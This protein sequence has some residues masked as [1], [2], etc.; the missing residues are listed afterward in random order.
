[1]KN[2]RQFYNCSIIFLNNRLDVKIL[3]YLCR[4]FDQQISILS[5]AI[6]RFLA[7]YVGFVVLFVLQR[8]VFM[9]IYSHLIGASGMAPYFQAI[10]HG[11]AMDCSIA[12]YLSIIPGLLTVAALWTSARWLTMAYR[13][14]FGIVSALLAFIFILDIGLYG[15][16]GFRLDM[17]PFFYMTSS[18]AAAMASVNAMTVASGITSIL[19]IF[20]GCYLIMTAI[21]GKIAVKPVRT[22]PA[23]VMMLLITGLL[24]IPIRGGFTVS[25]MNLSRAYFSQNQ[26]LNHAAVNPAFSLM[27]SATHQ[28]DFGGQ[29]RFM[30]DDEA[31]R[32]LRELGE[33]TTSAPAVASDSLPLLND[34]RPDIYIV[35]LESFS[36]HLMPSLGGAPVALGL[37]S[38][39][40]DGLSF[41]SIYANSFRT[42]RG[43]P[44]ILSAFPAQ[45]S[46]SLMKYVEKT[47][48]LP[49]LPGELKKAGYDIA[50]FYGGDANFTNMQAY[51]VNAGFERIISDK[52]FPLK[53]K[54][55]KWGAHDHLL[56]DKVLDDVK[57]SATDDRPRLRVIQTSSSHEPFEVPYSSPR[58][59]GEPEKNAFAYTDSC[60]T[61]WVDSMRAT[62]CYDRSLIVL[63]PDHQ[64]CFPRDIDDDVARHHIP[65]VMTGGAL[66]R[67]GMTDATP[68]SQIDI[69]ATLLGAM[70][71]DR[72]RLSYSKDLLADGPHYAVI[73]DPST[74]GIVTAS[75]TIVYN[76]DADM[77]VAAGGKRAGELRHRARAYLQRLY[78]NIANL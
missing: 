25:S 19:V 52:D 46:M 35:I 49:S 44:A 70:G 22:V 16:W 72:S 48:G 45:P 57:A 13:I 63:V 23:T 75:D 69:A 68:G 10:A 9:L 20:A 27:Y 42:D 51:L 24:F 4:S 40:R 1:M 18:P 33:E 2:L 12:G 8:I 67:R 53:D 36:A 34:R 15:Y 74:I 7:I 31:D 56:F 71:L 37:D 3:E 61:A 50:Y 54:T 28:H 32:A 58:F 26:R 43:I 38:I 41:T 66:A 21:T 78:D 73:S 47:E 76:C 65:L 11:L 77:T 60:L 59:A 29:Y 64:G 14:Y 17:T 39:A 55:G 5:K 62:P 6:L 30:T